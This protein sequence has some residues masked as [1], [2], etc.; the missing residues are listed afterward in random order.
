MVRAC[1][2]VV[3]AASRVPSTT[4]YRP[5]LLLLLLAAGCL[6][7]L[8]VSGPTRCR[9]RGPVSQESNC[10]R[11]LWYSCLEVVV[12]LLVSGVQVLTIKHFFKQSR[13]T[14]RLSV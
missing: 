7:Q 5:L 4:L 9:C 6:R 3:Q 13:Q 10:R 1:S 2:L 11:T 8:V 14:I 12:L